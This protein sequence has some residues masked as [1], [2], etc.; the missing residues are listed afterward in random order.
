MPQKGE[1]IFRREALLSSSPFGILR[2]KRASAAVLGFL[3]QHMK[4]AKGQGKGIL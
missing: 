2:R 1:I 4:G 3:L